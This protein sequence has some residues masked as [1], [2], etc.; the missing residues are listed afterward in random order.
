MLLTRWRQRHRSKL[1]R[2]WQLSTRNAVR[3]TKTPDETR[4]PHRAE[5]KEALA[6]EDLRA[7]L[8]L[9][10]EFREVLLA[11]AESG[12]RLTLWQRLMMDDE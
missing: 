10:Q 11:L 1:T 9:V 6:K 7:A 4:F 8:A 5:I 2:T 12:D 3:R